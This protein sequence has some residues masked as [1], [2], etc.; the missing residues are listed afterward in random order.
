[1]YS[2]IKY[3]SIA[4]V[5]PDEYRAF[6]E[7]LDKVDE[8]DNGFYVLGER[9]TMACDNYRHPQGIDPS[10]P[11]ERKLAEAVGDLV[12]AL[13]KKGVPAIPGVIDTGTKVSFEFVIHDSNLYIRALSEKGKEIAGILGVKSFEDCQDVEV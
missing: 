3:D 7:A 12:A 6:S 8:N 13:E 1:M 9:Y 10:N 5:C 4:T 11:D 2:R